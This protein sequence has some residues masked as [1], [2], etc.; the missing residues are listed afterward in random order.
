MRPLLPS[1]SLPLCFSSSYT[2]SS[3]DNPSILF[4][5]CAIIFIFIFTIK[6]RLQN[7]QA[8][9]GVI[10]TVQKSI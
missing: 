6:V 9:D 2:L 1:S 4:K 3:D 8:H 5:C 7:S 10:Y